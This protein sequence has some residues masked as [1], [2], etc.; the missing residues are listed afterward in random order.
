MYQPLSSMRKLRILVWQFY[1]P[2]LFYNLLFT[3]FGLWLT[4]GNTAA[5]ILAFAAK[6]VSYAGMFFYQH[7]F[8][9]Q[10]YFYY[11]NAGM[12]VRKVYLYAFAP[13]FFVFMLL[14]ILTIAL[15][16]YGIC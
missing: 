4:L 8:N 15:K 3:G 12:P 16:Q 14:N 1:K 10:Q 7:T 6:L 9:K 2:F 13:D 11:R 5:F